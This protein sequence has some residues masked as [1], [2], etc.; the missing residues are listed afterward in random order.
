MSETLSDLFRQ[1]MRRAPASVY[2]LATAQD[3]E[4]AGMTATAVTSLSF[5]PL[6]MLVCVHKSASCHPMLLAAGRFS[7]SLLSPADEAVAIAF[8]TSGTEKTRFS[9]GRWTEQSGLPALTTAAATMTLQIT[10]RHDAA[11]H[12]VFFGDV[13]S[14]VLNQ[15]DD[16]LLYGA[17]SF[18][19]FQA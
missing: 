13:E 6:S 5:D 18:G 2:I 16:T 15:S 7:L 3:G 9:S 12:T 8:S 19:G 1:A 4:R 14:V 11:T 10:A 17:G